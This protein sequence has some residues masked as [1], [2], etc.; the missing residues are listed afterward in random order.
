MVT[1]TNKEIEFVK[2]DLR[3]RGITMP[4]LVN[5]VLDHL[6]CGTEAYMTKGYSFSE[7]YSLASFDLTGEEGVGKIQQETSKGLNEWKNLSRNLGLYLLLILA[8]I[9]ASVIFTHGVNPAVILTCIS[10]GIFFIYHSIFQA[11]KTDSTRSN[12]LLFLL[13]TSIAATAV[14]IFLKAEFDF[15]LAGTT[16]WILLVISLAIPVYMKAVKDVLVMDRTVVSLLEY[17]LK[18]TAV[19]CLLWIPLVSCLH[20]FRPEVS[21]AFFLDDLIFLT[22]G[23]SV[24]SLALG[25]FNDFKLYLKKNLH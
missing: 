7:A 3:T 12:M 1:L 10:L 13:V 14:L 19:I 17:A 20:F 16:G 24:L 2:A 25:K 6:L 22:A 18:F 8:L 23:S 11:R 21:F 15:R 9:G 4:A 5:D